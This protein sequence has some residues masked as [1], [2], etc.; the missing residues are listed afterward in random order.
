M[1]YAKVYAASKSGLTK[2]TA[3][4]KCHVHER[5]LGRW[6]AKF[7][8]LD[9]QAIHGSRRAPKPDGGKH[10]LSDLQLA[11]LKRIIA[12]RTP[13]LLKFKFAL[14]SSEAVRELVFRRYGAQISRR[15]A[16]RY[17]LKPGFTYKTPIRLAGEQNPA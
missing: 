17:M 7:A 14:W 16:R 15:T 1:S 4:M 9:I 12:D 8:E 10:R 11:E 2:Y 13:D 5:A 3:A 6:Y